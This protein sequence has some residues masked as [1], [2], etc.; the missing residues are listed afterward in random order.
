MKTLELLD[1]DKGGGLLPAIVQHADTGAVLMLGF[2]NREA[3]DATLAS[4]HVVFWSRTKGRLWEKGESSGH[5]LEVEEIRPDCDRDALLIRARPKGPTCHLGMAS[6]FGEVEVTKLAFLSRIEAVIEARMKERPEGSYTTKLLDSGKTRLA[7][8]IGEEGLELA[9]ASV[10]QSD[11]AVIA[12]AADLLFH[13]I[14]MLK[15][16]GL[17]LQRVAEELRQRHAGK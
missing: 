5:S 6:C 2:M 8:K 7:Q 16:R 14:V 3:C 4:N 11:E 12:E 10:A 13:V 15:S 17:G 9:L 1:F